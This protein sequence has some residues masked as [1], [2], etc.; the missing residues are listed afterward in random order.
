MSGL[1]TAGEASGAE[2]IVPA[3]G[4]EVVVSTGSGSTS[5]SW[6]PSKLFM[7]R[8]RTLAEAIIRWGSQLPGLPLFST[9]AHCRASQ[10]NW[11]AF[12][13]PPFPD[14]SLVK[15]MRLHVLIIKSFE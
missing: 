15:F 4:D 12:F 10:S 11:R 9:V 14:L 1:A 8:E 13:T 6:L 5:C 7:G 3:G 2:V